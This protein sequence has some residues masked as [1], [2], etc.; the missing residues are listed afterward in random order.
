MKK[1]QKKTKKKIPLIKKLFFKGGIPE[2]SLYV[3]FFMVGIISFGLMMVGVNMPTLPKS[4]LDQQKLDEIPVVISPPK[5]KP[6]QNSL[7]LYTFSGV[8]QTPTPPPGPPP[9]TCNPSGSVDV[10]I[11]MDYSGSM[12][13]D[14][15]TKSKAA[16]NEFIDILSTN[17]SNNRIGLATFNENAILQSGFTGQLP[18][19]KATISNLPDGNGYTCIKCGIEV[20]NSEIQTNTRSGVN[21]VA[22][23]LSDG[24]AN[25]P[26]PETNAIQLTIDTVKQGFDTS[27]TKFY[28]IGFN[29]MGD[30]TGRKNSNSNTQCPNVD[31]D[32]MTQL[33][34]MTGGKYYCAPTMD[35]LRFIL[36][37]I[38]VIIC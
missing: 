28:T 27:K 26:K 29:S 25:R 6:A 36:S 15:L 19:L 33:A 32:L 16:I 18:M 9:K 21:K 12:E 31:E 14:A 1:K 13:G 11:I 35:H 30:Q 20:A 10:M 37:E 22:I 2:G 23:L 17:Q 4:I 8:K 3:I 24:N 34:S 38:G 5:A 7:Q